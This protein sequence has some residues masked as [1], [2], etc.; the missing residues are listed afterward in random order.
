MTAAILNF[1]PT[2]RVL[3]SPRCPPLW[4]QV[5]LLRQAQ[6]RN[7]SAFSALH[8]AIVDRA[9][10]VALG[11]DDA[12]VGEQIKWLEIT[13]RTLAWHLRTVPVAYE[14]QR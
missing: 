3:E 14:V 11:G 5:L 7:P 8:R 12:P 13:T 1:P 9:E 6:A 4:Q 10:Q 2:K